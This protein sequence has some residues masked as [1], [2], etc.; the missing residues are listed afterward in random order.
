MARIQI[1][2]WDNHRGLSHDIGL[3]RGTLQALGHQVTVTRL[4]QRRH[5]GRWKALPMWLHQQLLRLWHLDPRK[6]LFDLN[7]ALEHVRP[8][9]FR[10]ARRNVLIPNPEWLSAR[11][12]K[13][14]PRFDA[15]LCKTHHAVELFQA[16]GC[17]A[18]YIGF[19]SDDCL[20]RRIA[21]E[22]TFLHMAGASQMKG[23]AR[24]LALWQRHPEWPQ[25]LLLQSAA[26]AESSPTQ[27]NIEHRVGFVDDIHIIRE[28]Q[29]RHVFH[30]CLSETEG[31]GH[32]I[33][34]AMSAGA[35]VITCDAAPMNELVS[36]T[37]GLLVEAHATRSYNMATLQAFDEAALER[38]IA[39]AAAMTDEQHRAL[40][41]RARQWFEA[42][43]RSFPVQLREALD[44]LL[45]DP[46]P[47]RRKSAAATENSARC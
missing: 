10:F 21:R 40:G 18:L 41:Q 29:N 2:A 9:F 32:Y 44:Q 6:Q 3:L 19:R 34:E 11:S 14:L 13:Y 45:V 38:V 12:C 43:E 26:T 8:A 46:V 17:T 5:D 15:V 27:D 28:L 20:D 31:W 33:A 47:A 23:T 35:V 16:Q 37:R 7:I 39:Q 36:A 4:G 1:L 24:L 25:L 30:L 22:T 42:N